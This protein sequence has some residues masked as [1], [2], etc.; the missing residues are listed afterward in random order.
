MKLV[1]STFKIGNMFGVKNLIPRGLRTCV[2][3]KILCADCIACYVGETSRHLST[4]VREHLVSDRT[5]HIF[6]HLHNS[7]QCRT[8]CS[9]E[10]FSILDHPSTTF[11]LKIKEAIHIQWE[12]PILNH[13]LHHVNLKLSL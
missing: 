8:P 4:R 5:S 13:Q 11:Q 9:D 2:V 3:Y 7:P 10:Y 12:Q 6:K 1:F